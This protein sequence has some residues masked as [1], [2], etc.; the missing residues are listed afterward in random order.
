VSS[1]LACNPEEAIV[2]R[3]AFISAGL[4]A[5]AGIVRSTGARAQATPDAGPASAPVDTAAAGYCVDKGGTVVT[6]QPV[7]GA[8]LDLASRVVLGG[9]T[10]FCDFRGMAGDDSAISLSLE[11]LY[12]E[13]PTL[14]ALAY[15]T[16]PPAPKDATGAN[17]STLYCIHL[18]GAYNFG[19][20]MAEGGWVATDASADQN[21]TNYCVF[22]DGSMIDAWGLTYHSG[23]VIR[24][25]DLTPILRYQATEYPQ[26]F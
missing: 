13:Q 16:K 2:I 1:D 9:A 8:N 22:A 19:S 23:G 17:P 12:S 15:L 21:V 20:S 18:G 14:T 26:A 4:L 11:T 3:R 10:E 24:G 6:R 25:A 7:L 5:L